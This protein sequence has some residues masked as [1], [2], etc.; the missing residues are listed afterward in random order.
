MRRDPF[1]RRPRY[2]GIGFLLAVVVLGCLVGR[3]PAARQPTVTLLTTEGT[4]RLPLETYVL[5]VLAAEMPADA[6]LSALEAQAVAIRTYTLYHHDVLH[7]GTENQV[8]R[9][10][11]TL[12]RA[13]YT[14]LW[15]A[16]QATQG[17]YLEWHGHPALTVYSAAAGPWSESSLAA[18]GLALPYLPAHPD[19]YAVGRKGFR[20]V[21]VVTRRVWLRLFG[22]MTPAVRRDVAGY[23]EQ[24]G[25]QSGA[26]AARYLG[27]PSRHFVYH[28]ASRTVI[29]TV[30]GSGHGVGL[31][32]WGAIVMAERGA[33]YRQILRFYYPGTVF[34]RLGD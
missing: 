32:Q 21:R 28:L 11:Q 19:P 7:D 20:T 3:P 22:T 17:L 8:Y 18:F 9:D 29:V 26:E 10:P 27:L 16:V 34:G 6:P 14:R 12:S 5:G 4:L 13:A 23:V 25:R 30:Y 33:S 24:I 2:R 1:P 31:D 15:L